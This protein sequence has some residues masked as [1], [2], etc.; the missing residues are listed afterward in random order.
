MKPGSVY[1]E[2]EI[3]HETREVYHGF[4]RHFA[5]KEQQGFQMFCGDYNVAMSGARV[6]S[7]YDG[8]PIEAGGPRHGGVSDH[9]R[10]AYE[11]VMEIVRYLTPNE[12]RDAKSIA[13]GS[14]DELTA[15]RRLTIQDFATAR[16]AAY[17]DKNDQ[18]KVSIGILKALGE[19]LYEL[20]SYIESRDRQKRMNAPTPKSRAI[21]RTST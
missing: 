13:L 19:R 6:T 16:G 8:M 15:G 17:R 2:P 21:T 12:R 9:Q 4:E 1:R 7:R 18:A 10:E 5:T 20:Y 14:M 11:R 3:L